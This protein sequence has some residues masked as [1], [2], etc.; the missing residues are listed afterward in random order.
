MQNTFLPIFNRIADPGLP[1]FDGEGTGAGAGGD[2]GDGSALTMDAVKALV[3]DS[4]NRTVNNAISN[5]KKSDLPKIIDTAVAPLLTQMTGIS[6]NLTKLTSGQGSGTGQGTGG[7]GGGTAAPPEINAKMKELTDRLAHNDKTIAELQAARDNA[8]KA[9]R[10]A[11]Q[12]SAIREALG[13]LKFV[14][15]S[16]AETAFTLVGQQVKRLDDGT[17]V[18]G[19]DLPIKDFVRDF[20]PKSHSYLIAPTG[21]TGSGAGGNSGTPRPQSGKA[22][23]NSIVPGMSPEARAAVVAAINDAVSATQN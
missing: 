22:D 4:V 3:A 13:E 12:N 19:D 9:A 21:T 15:P 16:A 5:L 2:S 17:L 23:L 1:G 8:E 6:E 14:S 10:L 20:V 7:S 11:E 18:A